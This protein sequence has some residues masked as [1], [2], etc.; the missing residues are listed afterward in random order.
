MKS[1]LITGAASGIGADLARSLADSGYSIIATDINESGLVDLKNSPNAQIFTR[2][3]DVTSSKDWENLFQWIQESR[4]ELE[5]VLNVAGY[6][7]PG[8]VE[9]ITA[10]D[11]DRHLDINVKGVIH[12]TRVAVRHWLASKQQGHVVNIASM[13]ALA[14]IPGL[15]LYSASKFAV[16]AFSIAAAQELR[17]K[18]IYVSVV[19]PDA[20]QTPMLELQKKYDS[21]AL[22]FSGRKILTVEEVTQAIIRK[23][24][25]NR[26]IETFLPAQRGWL[27]RFADVF[28][29]AAVRIS[30]HLRKRGLSKQAEMK[31]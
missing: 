9:E 31:S 1:V 2:R 19:C 14:P 26:P 24:I 18:G 23:V 20:V 17:P 29:G 16:R 7:L 28:P 27:A 4:F 25:P 22:T 21:A 5:I 6:L 11:V 12:G 8:W 15:G 10:E 3:L 13:A 30:P